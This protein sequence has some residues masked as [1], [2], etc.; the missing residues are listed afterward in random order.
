MSYNNIF[1]YVYNVNIWNTINQSINYTAVMH[2]IT[3]PRPHHYDIKFLVSTF[4]L[5]TFTIWSTTD[6]VYKHWDQIKAFRNYI[7]MK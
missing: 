6:T 2:P 5:N 3:V 7:Y 4:K 1:V